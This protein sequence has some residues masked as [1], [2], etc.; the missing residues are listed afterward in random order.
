MF[1]ILSKSSALN[2]SGLFQIAFLQYRVFLHL[3]QWFVPLQQEDSVKNQS[4]CRC[5][6]VAN[7]RNL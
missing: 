1:P 7:F 2:L 3:G 4:Y 6:S 5:L